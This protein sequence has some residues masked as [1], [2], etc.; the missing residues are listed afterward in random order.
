MSDLNL[1]QVIG[2][3]GRDPEVRYLP[4][5]EA[6]CNLSIGVGWKTKDKDGV[7]WVRCSAFGKLAE[8]CGK[9]LVKGKQVYVSGV[10]STREW[11]DKDG[12]RKFSTE[13]RLNQM[14]MLGD[15]KAK[16]AD[17]D[18]NPRSNDEDEIPF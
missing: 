7:E 14:Q 10:M 17:P 6:V 18:P 2:R 9:Y 16:G 8:I 5:G 3:L 11:S 1:C 4:S 15:A 13:I 12:A